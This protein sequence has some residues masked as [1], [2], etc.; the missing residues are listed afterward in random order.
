MA[1]EFQGNPIEFSMIRSSEIS[2]VGKTKVEVPEG[3]K[4]LLEKPAE[5]SED[6][7]EQ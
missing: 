5:K 2:A 7:K 4:K 3:V 1:I 6:K